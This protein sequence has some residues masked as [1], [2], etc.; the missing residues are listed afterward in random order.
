MVVSSIVKNAFIVA[1][2]RPGGINLGLSQ[3]NVEILWQGIRGM[4]I[5]Q[6]KKQIFAMLQY[7]DPPNYLFLH[8]SAN[9]IDH[10]K[11]GHIR[12]QIKVTINWIHNKLPNT[13]IIWSQILPRSCWRYSSNMIAMKKCRYR[14]N[15]SIASY[16]L[17]SGGHYIQCT[18]PRNQSY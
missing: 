5:E 7:E 16:V 10:S 15:N 17:R 1:R 11:I 14:L 18:L 6:I 9:N 2:Q 8:V 13:I 4:V 12:N 3:I